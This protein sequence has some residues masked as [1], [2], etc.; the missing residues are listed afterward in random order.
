LPD[1]TTTMD[2]AEAVGLNA[3][4]Q[5][6]LRFPFPADEWWATAPRDPA[7]W[8]AWF[9]RYRRFALHHADLAARGKEQVVSDRVTW[10]VGE[11]ERGWPEEA[12]FDAIMVTAAGVKLIEYNAR[13]GDPEAMNVLSLL[14]T[15]FV[16]ICEAIIAGTL[17]QI[18]VSFSS[19]ASVCK[20]AVPEGYPDAPVKGRA[21]DFSRVNQ[22]RNLYYASVDI[23]DNVLVEAGS[24]TAAVVGLADSL[25]EAEALAEEEIKSIA[26]PLFHRSDIGT[27]ALV[28]K[29]VD[30]MRFLR[31]GA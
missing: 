12:P 22:P 26:G 21:V 25:Q 4:L 28:Q 3:A 14:E 15:D 29:R 7:W 5:P 10:Q 31:S 27:T 9:E 8:E 11:P 17:D 18:T 1:L 13:F 16:A 23:V 20:Y 30:H 19:R 2:Q 24:R 6:V